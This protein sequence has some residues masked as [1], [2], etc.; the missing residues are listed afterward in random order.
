M[1]NLRFV[2]KYCKDYTQIENYDKAIADTTQ[3]WIC[4]HILGEILSKQQLLDHDFY[5]EVPPCMLKFVTT[6]EHRC[7]HNKVRTFTEETRMKISESKKGMHHSE[8]TRMK[9]SEAHKGKRPK[10]L[11]DLHKSQKGKQR[12][13][14][15][16]KK[17]RD[18]WA[19]RK[20]AKNK[21]R[22][23]DV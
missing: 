3:K 11:D 23:S 6:A 4:H 8:E 1:I 19:R 9:M 10:N 12:T 16:K 21:N 14:E 15:T 2:K 5:Y 20:E 18:A 13:A 22:K 17:I 7:I